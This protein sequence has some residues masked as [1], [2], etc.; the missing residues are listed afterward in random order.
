MSEP[1]AFEPKYMPIGLLTAALQELT[2]KDKR[3]ADPDLAVEEWIQFGYECGAKILQMS[4]ALPE[5]L[6][7][8]PPE[9]MLDPVADH[10]MVQK[11]MTPERV[12]RI[13]G[14]LK[15][16]DMKICDI[17]Y[18]D[19]MLVGD[20]AKRKIK[21]DWMIKL[22]DAAVALDVPAVC[23]FVGRNTDLVGFGRLPSPM[24]DS[25]DPTAASQPFFKSKAISIDLGSNGCG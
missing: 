7:D 11:P 18:F 8:I 20:P 15:D 21:H 25:R 6:S 10:L 16:A 19:N 14:A 9:A 1:I 3:R 24:S 12:R 17:A 13:N 2:P 4:S 5:E 22:M 23:G